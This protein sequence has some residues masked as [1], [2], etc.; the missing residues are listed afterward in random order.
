MNNSVLR[1]TA[2]V[3]VATNHGSMLVNRHDYRMIEG[4]G[5]YGVG[6]QLLNT[7]SFDQREVDMALR[8]L[9]ARRESF[10]EGVMAIDCGANIGVHTVE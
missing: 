5:G 4:G 3:L 10:G 8:L 7:S 9:A 6:Y 2:F 1:P